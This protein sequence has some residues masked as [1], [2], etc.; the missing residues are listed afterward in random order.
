MSTFSLIKLKLESLGGTT[1]SSIIINHTHYKLVHSNS[2]SL[3]SNSHNQWAIRVRETVPLAKT[4][5]NQRKSSIQQVA[6]KKSDQTFLKKLQSWQ[7]KEM[8]SNPLNPHFWVLSISTTETLTICRSSSWNLT[9]KTTNHTNVN[10][11]S[12][13]ASSVQRQHQ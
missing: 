13:A 9:N 3:G 2:T 12:S 11:M 7:T 1:S 5:S 6:S 4:S 8:Q 10:I